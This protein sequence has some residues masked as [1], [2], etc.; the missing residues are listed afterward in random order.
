[1]H[2]LA[3][4]EKIEK[5]ESGLEAIWTKFWQFLV[6]IIVMNDDVGGGGGKEPGGK[7]YIPFY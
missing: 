7:R 4:W 3:Y 1:M 6:K 2:S 5:F